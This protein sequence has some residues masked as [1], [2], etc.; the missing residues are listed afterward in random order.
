[1]SEGMAQCSGQTFACILIPSRCEGCEGTGRLFMSFRS[2]LNSIGESKEM[3]CLQISDSNFLEVS[4]RWFWQVKLRSLNSN[5][6]QAILEGSALNIRIHKDLHMCGTG[7]WGG[8]PCLL[9]G[10][11]SLAFLIGRGWQAW[12][13]CKCGMLYR[14]R[15]VGVL[16][17]DAAQNWLSSHCHRVID[18]LMEVLWHHSNLRF[19]HHDAKWHLMSDG[20]SSYWNKRC[21]SLVLTLSACLLS[22]Y[23]YMC[24][25]YN[26]LCLMFP[27]HLSKAF[28]ASTGTYHQSLSGSRF[29]TSHCHHCS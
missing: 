18:T 10:K 25:V 29:Q 19:F 5:L 4:A 12:W 20:C 7:W 21:P 24:T 13:N 14:H 1:M 26:F 11:S 2:P 22:R 28:L 6:F 23:R 16:W 27:S 15:T 8:I 3:A 9:I 17:N